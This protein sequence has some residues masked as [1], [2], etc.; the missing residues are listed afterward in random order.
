MRRKF[1]E[2]MQIVPEEGVI[3]DNEVKERA[4]QI[5]V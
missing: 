3:Y 5:G 2:L 1:I 4:A